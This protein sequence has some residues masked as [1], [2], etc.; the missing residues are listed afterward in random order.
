LIV[1][2]FE[3][4]F[5][6]FAVRNSEIEK[7]SPWWSK[8]ERMIKILVQRILIDLWLTFR[9]IGP[10]WGWHCW[11]RVSAN[12]P[13]QILRGWGNG[14]LKLR[15]RDFFT[16][17]FGKSR[18]LSEKVWSSKLFLEVS[19]D[20][21]TFRSEQFC[22]RTLGGKISLLEGKLF[23]NLISVPAWSPGSPFILT[24]IANIDNRC[25]C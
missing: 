9:G 21:L 6:V 14:L 18:G 12:R 15:S 5:A 8:E 4:A 23:V 17:G 11:E 20:V 2:A 22:A 25:D 24:V 7:G 3:S 10:S 19:W 13:M 1:L 16:I